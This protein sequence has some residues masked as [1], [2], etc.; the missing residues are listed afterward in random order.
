MAAVL[1][2]Y[3]LFVAI[4]DVMSNKTVH[5]KAFLIY[6]SLLRCQS[7]ETYITVVV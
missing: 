1:Y 7:D 2:V 4:V 5:L 3:E 6:K